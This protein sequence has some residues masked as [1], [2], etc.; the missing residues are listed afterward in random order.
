[1]NIK[2]LDLKAESKGLFY[3]YCSVMNENKEEIYYL[4]GQ[5]FIKSGVYVFN[6]ND[7]CLSH[8]YVENKINN[9][10]NEIIKYYENNEYIEEKLLKEMEE[11]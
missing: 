10:E 8:E 4:N 9:I 11:N 2:I 1:M 5:V 6:I 3:S 7:K